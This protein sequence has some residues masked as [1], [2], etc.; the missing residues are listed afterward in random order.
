MQIVNNAYNAFMKTQTNT[1]ASREEA[2]TDV[3]IED[4]LWV[5][6]IGADGFGHRR[7]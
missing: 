5:M 4:G 6:A 7:N 1:E 2:F 3:Y